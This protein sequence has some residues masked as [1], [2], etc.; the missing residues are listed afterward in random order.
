MYFTSEKLLDEFFENKKKGL[1]KFI[2]AYKK[3]ELIK[4]A[5]D[6][7]IKDVTG[8]KKDISKRIFD[9]FS[10]PGHENGEKNLRYNLWIRLRNMAM[11]KEKAERKRLEEERIANLPK[12]YSDMTLEELKEEADE[13]NILSSGTEADIIDRLKRLDNGTTLYE[14]SND[15]YLLDVMKKQGLIISKLRTDNIA[16]LKRFDRYP[17]LYDY[18]DEHLKEMLVKYDQPVS[19]SRNDFLLRLY[20]IQ[21]NN[22]SE[23]YIKVRKNNQDLSQKLK[24]KPTRVYR[25]TYRHKKK[26]GGSG[27]GSF[28]SGAIAGHVAS[29]IFRVDP[30][31]DL[32]F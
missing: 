9:S 31:L 11:E 15:K 24:N 32:K 10:F 1:E 30:K 3:D 23:K 16:R 7:S 28:V 29:R 6:L 22:L 14:D 2:K 25:R 12:A 13:E 5:T 18:T 8:T 4:L 17:C 27:F 21:I 26:S 19:G 20:P